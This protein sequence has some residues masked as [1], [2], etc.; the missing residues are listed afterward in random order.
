MEIITFTALLFAAFANWQCM[1]LR[2]KF[3]KRSQDFIDLLQTH[4][5]LIRG[6]QENFG[7]HLDL[8][9]GYVDCLLQPGESLEV[10]EE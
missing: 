5:E 4:T 3:L 8:H 1:D 9:R 7:A 2:W 10:T 6:L